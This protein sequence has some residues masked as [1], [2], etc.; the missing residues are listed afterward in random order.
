MKTDNGNVDGIVLAV[1]RMNG[2]VHWVAMLSIPCVALMTNASNV[3]NKKLNKKNGI[4]GTPT[5]SGAQALTHCK[6]HVY[7]EKNLSTAPARKIPVESSLMLTGI[8]SRLTTPKLK[9]STPRIFA[10]MEINMEICHN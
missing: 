2:G 1:K 7:N 10:Q 4:D 6:S 8:G 9:A 5:L 3:S